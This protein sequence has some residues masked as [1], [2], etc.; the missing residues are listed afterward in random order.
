MDWG[1]PRH[2]NAYKGNGRCVVA[3]RDNRCSFGD[4]GHLST[5]P[6]A[7]INASGHH[8]LR[9]LAAAGEIRNLYIE[10][11]FLEEAEFLGDVDRYDR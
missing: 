3:D 1:V 6:D 5:G 4:K 9:Q 8:G 10:A 7:N 11:M 2:G